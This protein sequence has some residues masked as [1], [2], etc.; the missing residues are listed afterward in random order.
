MVTTA[1]RTAPVTDRAS[2]TNRSLLRHRP[3]A[4]RGRNIVACVA[5]SAAP[6]SSLAA[7]SGSLAQHLA[8]LVRQDDR[9]CMIGGGRVVVMF[10]DVDP[11]LNAHVL[12]ARL[13]RSAA[14]AST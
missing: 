9:I 3:A 12:G 11:S 14:Q 8:A 7:V 13:A 10:Q 5:I 6:S 4:E 2:A 1:Q